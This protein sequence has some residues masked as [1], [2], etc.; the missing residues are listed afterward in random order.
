FP[1]ETPANRVHWLKEVMTDT[2][3]NLG[4]DLRQWRQGVIEALVSINVDTVVFTHFIA[5]NVAVGLAINDTRVVCF[6]PDNASI[7]VLETE[8]DNLVLMKTGA[9]A[10]TSIT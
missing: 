10:D 7:T 5:I 2:W 8:G 4:Q 1:S 9:E 6:K 3:P